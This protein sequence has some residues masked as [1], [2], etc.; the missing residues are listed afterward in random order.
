VKSLL[1]LTLLM[2]ALFSLTL[3]VAVGAQSEALP[4]F[5]AGACPFTPLEGA[6]VECGVLIVP[7]DR[8]NPDPADTVALAV[9][10][11]RADAP[12]GDPVFFLQGGPGGGIVAVINVYYGTAIAPITADRDFVV[13]DQRGTGLSTPALNCPEVT[14]LFTDNLRQDYT[15]DQVNPLYVEAFTVCGETLRDAGIDLTTYTS[16]TSAADIIDLADSFGYGSIALY[17]GS[18]GTRLAQTVMRDFPDRISSAVLDG[19][20]GIADNQIG[21]IASKSDWALNNLFEACAAEAACDAAYP[22]LETIFYETVAR[23]DAAPAP[24]TVTIPTT[25]EV[26]ETTADGVDL[27][28][29]VFLGLQQTP[30]IASVP[31]TIQAVANGDTSAL[32]TF[33]SLP[34]L[35]GDAINIGAFASVICA[36]EIP[37][38]T[39]AALDAEAAAFPRFTTFTNSVYYGGGQAIVDLCAAWGAAPFDP[40]EGE[41]LTS[42]IPTLL[43]SGQ[44]DPATPPYFADAVAAG[45]ST[46]YNYVIPGAGHVSSLDNSCANSIVRDFLADPTTEPDSSCLA[47]GAFAF[48]TPT[49]EIALVPVTNDTF[50]YTSVIPQGWTEV[51]PGTYAVSMTGSVALIQQV[52]PAPIGD[53]KTLLTGQLGID[54]FPEVIETIT[55]ANES[56]LTWERYELSIQGQA[57]DLALAEVGGTSYMIL[58]ISTPAERTLYFDGLFLP[59]LEAFMPG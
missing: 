16:A 55:T 7:E 47:A 1:R 59:V 34:V 10:V 45:L 20:L 13:F 53:L 3:G 29:G 49:T 52:I 4:R 6:N 23:L 14:A 30:L 21:I 44:F 19:V 27:I 39:P 17:G 22:E 40:I 9:A 8:A 54:P 33:L 43:L 58:L 11:Y 46:S 36:E 31:S 48:N 51:S 25:G 12:T 28:G 18:Y 38:T 26:I 24:V 5:E 56:G 37:A 42:D 35:L 57:G 15:P 50:G 32:A 41:V 2:I